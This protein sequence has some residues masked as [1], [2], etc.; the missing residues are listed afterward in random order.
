VP[1]IAGGQGDGGGD[2]GKME[3]IEVKGRVRLV[4]SALFAELV[5]SGEDGRDWYVEGADRQKL[6]GM[7]QR[8]VTVRGRAESRDFVLANGVKAGVRWFL[9]DIELVKWK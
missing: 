8:E 1:A 3:K 7:E 9:R 4:G 5:V 6:S 2:T